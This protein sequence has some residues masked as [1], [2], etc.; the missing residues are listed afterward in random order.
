VSAKLDVHHNGYGDGYHDETGE[1]LLGREQERPDLMQVLCR[2][3]HD[4]KHGIGRSPFHPVEVLEP[5][6]TLDEEIAVE[7]AERL[8]KGMADGED[9]DPGGL[10]AEIVEVEMLCGL[11][12][13]PDDPDL[14]E[15]AAEG[16]EGYPDGNYDDERADRTGD[17]DPAYWQEEVDEIDL[18][19]AGVDRDFYGQEYFDEIAP[20]T[21]RSQ[22]VKY[23]ITERLDLPGNQ[24]LDLL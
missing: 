9:L 10:A 24:R 15:L 18:E 22:M 17:T 21:S 6:L 4:E 7:L 20:S 5:W 12:L 2:D 16:L 11:G 23:V 14:G 3:C 13:D 1:T 19:D 8:W